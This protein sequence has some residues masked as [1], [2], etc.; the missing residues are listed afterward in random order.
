ML[1]D[2]RNLLE[3]CQLK[4]EI[5]IIGAGSAGITIA[6]EFINLKFKITFESGG[7]KFDPR[8]QS[9]SKGDVFS[10]TK[11]DLKDSRRR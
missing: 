5:C 11:S 10:P 3:D 7:S 2:G 9:L 6:S 8:L 1:V 4:T